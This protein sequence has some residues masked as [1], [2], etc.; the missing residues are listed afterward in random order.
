[1]PKPICAA[2]GGI[3]AMATLAPAHAAPVA[4]ARVHAG[5]L[6]IDAHLDLPETFDP[7][8]AD[9]PGQGQFSL[10]QARQGGLKGAVIAV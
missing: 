4:V 7:A 10:V 6:P 2:L 3:L 5:A 9:A 8:R 1:M